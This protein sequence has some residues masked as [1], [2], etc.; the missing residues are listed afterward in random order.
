MF[1]EIK[2]GCV[3]LY[4]KS[5]RVIITGCP[6]CHGCKYQTFATTKVSGNEF[7]AI[8][9]MWN[10]QW[11]KCVIWWVVDVWTNTSHRNWY[12]KSL[13]TRRVG[14]SNFLV[15][16]KENRTLHQTDLKKEPVRKK[17]L[18]Y[19][20]AN[21]TEIVLWLHRQSRVSSYHFGKAGSKI[22]TWPQNST[23]CWN[24]S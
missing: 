16:K 11:N 5:S 22:A 1:T 14:V 20:F 4:R 19:F 21:W 6:G 15:A 10:E 13:Y 18:Y 17:Y 23:R 24:E 3:L 12:L 9:L 7:T 8:Q 2:W